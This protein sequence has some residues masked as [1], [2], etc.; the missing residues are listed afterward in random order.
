MPTKPAQSKQQKYS[1]LLLR[2][3]CVP[4]SCAPRVCVCECVYVVTW[5]HRE[6]VPRIP[7]GLG[8]V[9][10]SL[11]APWVALGMRPLHGTGEPKKWRESPPPLTHP[12]PPPPPI[13]MHTHTL[14]PAAKS[15]HAQTYRDTHGT[16]SRTT[17]QLGTFRVSLH[18]TFTRCNHLDR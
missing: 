13:S 11:Q 15:A 2:V 4:V 5:D 6:N 18:N 16:H 8:V 1:T 9:A 7:G 3:L 14:Y 12:P 10:R 17:D